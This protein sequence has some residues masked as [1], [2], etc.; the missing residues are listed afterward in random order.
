MT[1]WHIR[2]NEGGHMNHLRVVL[3]ELKEH[4][5]LAKHRKWEFWLSLVTFHG[6]SIFSKGVEVNPWKT[7]AVKNWPRPLTP[8]DNKSI[9][10]LAGYY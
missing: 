10:G 6:N 9:L 7:R 1:Y 8:T 5:L 3:H 4:Q 2:K